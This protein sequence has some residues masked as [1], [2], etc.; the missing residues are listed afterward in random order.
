MSSSPDSIAP[1]R[2]D[3]K[4]SARLRDS[5]QPTSELVS[6]EEI[7]AILLKPA[8]VFHSNCTGEPLPASFLRWTK[9]RW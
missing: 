2:F 6:Q 8:H 3:D 5:C 4:Y 1:G 9:T 7:E